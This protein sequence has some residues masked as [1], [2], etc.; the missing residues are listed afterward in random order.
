MDKH[1]ALIPKW[2][3]VNRRIRENADKKLDAGTTVQQSGA[4][5][6]ADAQLGAAFS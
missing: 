3:V 6:D 2:H 5:G 1:N 4:A